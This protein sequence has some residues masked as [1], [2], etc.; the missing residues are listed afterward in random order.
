[1]WK[2]LFFCVFIQLIYQN[3]GDPI[4]PVQNPC[5]AIL[6]R[7]SETSSG[8]LN[9]AVSRARP[10]KLCEGCV[11]NYAR[12]QDLIGLLDKTYSD[13]DRKITCKGFLESYD[14][15]QIVAQLISFV[16]NIWISSYCDNCITGYKDTNGTIDYS[17]TDDTK[18]FIQKKL[19]FDFCIFNATGRMVPIIPIDLNVTLNT[20]V[21]SV[22]LTAYNSINEFFLKITQQNNNGVCMDIVDTMNYTRLLWSKIYE[23]R[24]HDPDY[25][26]V[27][28]ISFFI[29][30]IVLVFYISALF[31]G[32][33]KQMKLSRQK[34]LPPHSTTAAIVGARTWLWSNPNE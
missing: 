15:I 13:V 27:I 21:C 14:T 4:Y 33:R 17:L 2:Q 23:C 1:M 7:L 12:L 16:E 26:A 24:R 29:P 6:D 34:R 20:N 3:T 10:F 19:N 30:T 8:F 31:K 22:C 18:Q 25:V 28:G 11:D 9:C 32:E 5:L